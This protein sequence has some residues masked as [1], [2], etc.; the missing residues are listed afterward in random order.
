MRAEALGAPSVERVTM[1]RALLARV[2]AV[3][4]AASLLIAWW[5]NDAAAQQGADMSFDINDTQEGGDQQ[6]GGADM[7][8]TQGD[9]QQGDQQQQGSGDVIGDLAGGQQEGG[10]QAATDRP[11]RNEA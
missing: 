2:A 10:Q 4:L 6:Q 5:S 7:D 1:N 3:G 8:F 9:Q 11:D